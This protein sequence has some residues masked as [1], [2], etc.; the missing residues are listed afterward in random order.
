MSPRDDLPGGKLR[1]IGQWGVSLS[2]SAMLILFAVAY[3]LRVL[4]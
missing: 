4:A 3:L 1:R 2:V